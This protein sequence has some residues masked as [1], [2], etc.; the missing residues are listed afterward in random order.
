MKLKGSYTVE[1]AVV[2]SFCFIVFGVAIGVAYDLFAAVL[3]TISYKEDVF[4]AVDLFRTKEGVME[5]WKS[6]TRG[7]I[8]TALWS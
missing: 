5:L 1:A 7:N 4:D 6:L 8:M 2:I 3:E